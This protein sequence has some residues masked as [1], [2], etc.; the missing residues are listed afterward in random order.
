MEMISEFY[1]LLKKV[2]S[3]HLHVSSYKAKDFKDFIK[4]LTFVTS[5]CLLL[6]LWFLVLISSKSFGR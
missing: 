4:C 3:R 2:E 1:L 5:S 6:S